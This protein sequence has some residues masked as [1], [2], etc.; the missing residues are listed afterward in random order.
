MSKQRSAK[1]RRRTRGRW[2]RLRCLVL[3]A[4]AASCALISLLSFWTNVHWWRVTAPQQGLV[5]SAPPPTPLSLPPSPFSLPSLLPVKQAPTR[6]ALRDAALSRKLQCSQS[7][8][9]ATGRLISATKRIALFASSEQLKQQLALHY[10]TDV[11]SSQL[12]RSFLRA[13]GKQI[14]SRYSSCAVVG[15]SS[16]VLA[17]RHGAFIDLHERVIRINR[18]YTRGFERYVGSRTTEN[19]FWGHQL[20]LNAFDRLVAEVKSTGEVDLPLGIIAASK[21]KDVSFFSAAAANR[22][23]EDGPPLLLLSDKVYLRSLAEL[24]HATDRGRTWGRD[25]EHG[26][27]VQRSSPVMRPSSGLLGVMFALHACANV[28]L[29]GLR[30]AD[31]PCLPHRYT[32]TLSQPTSSCKRV[33]SS[34]HD[35]PFHSFA[36]EHKLYTQTFAGAGRNQY[37]AS[38]VSIF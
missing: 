20:H 22:S 24:C 11:P 29:F 32:D 7:A 38:W 36:L 18:V 27:E 5:L 4:T 25:D 17:E 2:C 28:S 26:T 10:E 19:L 15:S 9:K 34:K 37:G 1:G 8:L 3:T 31:D 14:S 35:H 23:R 12:K 33:I 6:Q 16:S 13:L 21:A 30:D